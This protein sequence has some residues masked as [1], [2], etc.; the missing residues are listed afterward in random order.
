MV[1]HAKLPSGGAGASVDMRFPFLD[2][3]ANEFDRSERRAPVDD[4]VK[5]LARLR[6]FDCKKH[7]LACEDEN[8]IFVNVCRIGLFLEICQIADVY[9][10]SVR[11]SSW[12]KR[13]D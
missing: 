3:L 1:A 8:G 5:S 4:V 6:V 2:G 11:F 13:S 12:P 9:K 10:N 7:V